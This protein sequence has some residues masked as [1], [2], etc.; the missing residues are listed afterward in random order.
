MAN[1]ADHTVPHPELAGY[2]LR[3]LEPAEVERFEAHLATCAACRAEVA[4]L[5]A[6]PRLL[7]EAGE[8]P[9]AGL[10][11][12]TLT[13]VDRAARGR[14]GPGDTG[15]TGSLSGAVLDRI[16]V[17]W[18]RPIV[19]V[20]TVVLLA[21]LAVSTFTGRDTGQQPVTV[22][23]VA[24]AGE[25]GSG[26]AMI[27]QSAEGL[28]IRLSLHDLPPSRTGTYYECWYVGE[29]DSPE[30]P[31]RVSGGTF[32]VPASGTA[33]VAMTTAAD[34]RKYPGIAITLESDDGD[35]G[36]TGQVILVSGYR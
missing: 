15:V 2:V 9:P 16:R 17:V 21:V 13:A 4:D 34:Y 20:A 11:E 1:H 32:I 22:P 12:R 19:V 7:R 25:R 10:R 27:R 33:E 3:V 28:V 5:E 36:T 8:E 30:R 6:L 24:V 26:E 23:L 31:R 29:R 18:R 14:G 35:P